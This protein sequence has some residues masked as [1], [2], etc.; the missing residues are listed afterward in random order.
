MYGELVW[1]EDYEIGV[2]IID[3][4]HRR[5]FQIISKLFA[6][7]EEGANSHWACREGINQN[8]CYE[9]FQR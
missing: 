5:L 9:A 2:E 4:E 6:A 1:Q 7:K 3:K 8:P